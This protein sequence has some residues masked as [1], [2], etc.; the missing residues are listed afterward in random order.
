MCDPMRGP[1][2]RS[3]VGTPEILSQHSPP[4]P[5]LAGNWP[6][7]SCP[8]PLRAVRACERVTKRSCAYGTC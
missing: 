3:G 2:V 4:R 7:G 6:R 8:P 5:A 1:L